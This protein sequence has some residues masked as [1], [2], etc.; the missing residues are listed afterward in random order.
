MPTPKDKKER[1]KKREEKREKKKER[2]RKKEKKIATQ[3][4]QQLSPRMSHKA[5]KQKSTHGQRQHSER[6]TPPTK[7]TTMPRWMEN[8]N[9]SLS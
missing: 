2:K 7:S 1:E 6:A 3:L 5:E 8:R 9:K 4:S